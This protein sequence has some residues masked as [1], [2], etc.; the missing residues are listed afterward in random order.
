MKDS[1][2][3]HC[4]GLGLMR[5][6]EGGGEPGS[7][8]PDAVCCGGDAHFRPP[9]GRGTPTCDSQPQTE[10]DSPFAATGLQTRL[11]S[12]SLISSA[13]WSSHALRMWSNH[14]HLVGSACPWSLSA[15]AICPLSLVSP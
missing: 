11:I 3:C 14:Q 9:E 6:G 10:A 1:E 7:H 8:L 5:V 2:P 12:S 4:C 15:E 13:W